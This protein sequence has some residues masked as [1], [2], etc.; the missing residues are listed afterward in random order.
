MG[1]EISGSLSKLSKNRSLPYNPIGGSKLEGLNFAYTQER[2]TG[3]DGQ[4]HYYIT[5]DLLNKKETSK[6][7]SKKKN[8]KKKIRQ[9]RNKILIYSL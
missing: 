1:I 3:W 7:N 5:H 8:I 9:R 2:E 6:S 4:F